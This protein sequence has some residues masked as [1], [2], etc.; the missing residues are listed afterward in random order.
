MEE[1]LLGVGS[2]L[3]EIGEVEI[4]EAECTDKMGKREIEQE[5]LK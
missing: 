5:S 3:T 4:I 2:N 1:K